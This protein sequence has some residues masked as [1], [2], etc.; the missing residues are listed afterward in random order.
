MQ[1]ISFF[2]LCFL[3]A[4]YTQAQ[5]KTVY[6]F[7]EKATLIDNNLTLPAKLDTGAKLASLNATHIK[8]I[9]KNNKIYLRFTVPTEDNET[10]FECEFIGHANI[11]IRSDEM[12]DLSNIYAKRP[13]VRMQI[14]LANKEV[15]IRVNLIDRAH[16][17]YPLL[18]GRQ[19]I[20]AFGG[21]ID[22]SLKYTIGQ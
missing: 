17:T 4:Q 9:R 7:V 21:I 2:L 14:K 19:A 11:K 10:Q 18:L 16:F 20:I 22:P 6:G 3:F 12:S 15:S 13:M 1:R 8:K 5:E